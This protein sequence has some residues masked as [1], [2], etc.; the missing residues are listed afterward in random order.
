M[1]LLAI[2]KRPSAFLPVVMS[3][4]ATAATVLYIALHGTAPQAD[5]GAEAHIWQLMMAGQL[6]V[7]AFF[8]I[9]WL[10]QSPRQ[11]AIIM[12][13]QAGA[14]LAATAPIFLLGW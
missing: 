11:A 3:L 8:A 1:N 9:K 5:E 4:A 13:L 12:V 14:A 10:P 7:V 2:L 6:P